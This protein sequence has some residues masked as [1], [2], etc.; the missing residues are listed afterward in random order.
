MTGIYKIVNNI[1]G[2]VYIGQAHNVHARLRDHKECLYGN[3]HTNNHLLHAWN[4]YGSENFTFS[5]IEECSDEEL[6]E[7]E[8]YWIDYYGGINSDNTYNQRDASSH[9]T[10]SKETK[11]KISSL[12]KGIPK[13][14]GRTVSECGRKT[15]SE[16]HKGLH[17]SEETKRK[18]SIAQK[19]RVHSK[20][21]K[22][23]ISEKAKQRY[24]DNPELRKEISKRMAG[25]EFS[26]EHKRKLGDINRGKS[27]KH[28]TERI[29]KHSEGLRRAYETGK[30]KA[31]W[32]TVDDVTKMQTD[33]AKLLE[34]PHTSIIYQRR[35]GDGYA[36]K[37][38]HDM[39][40]KKNI[41]LQ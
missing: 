41:K 16:A 37:Y 40:L 35:K 20:E 3:R 10:H 32:I 6:T 9:G 1:N 4:K 2:K 12:M 38:I 5:I 36:E 27:Y 7:R 13:K 34:V 15:L 8:Q 18:M 28:D 25:R 11:Q 30:K 17:H 22:R 24:I 14:P 33:W 21:T 39:L 31:I 23:K 29:K 19:G 26:E